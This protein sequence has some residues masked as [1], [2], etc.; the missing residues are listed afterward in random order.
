MQGDE[1]RGL[2]GL[3]SPVV[4]RYY[5]YPRKNYIVMGNV[6]CMGYE[7]ITWLIGRGATG[8]TIA[9]TNESCSHLY[10]YYMELWKKKGA[11]ASLYPQ[12]ELTGEKIRNIFTLTCSSGQ[13]GGIAYIADSTQRLKVPTEADEDLEEMVDVVAVKAID[14]FTRDRQLE[15][16]DFFLAFAAATLA[17]IPG[18]AKQGFSNF[19]IQGIMEGRHDSGLPGKLQPCYI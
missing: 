3:D 17:G 14:T 11:S 13:L 4:P 19:S 10:N 16:L 12:T 6:D 8:V 1:E 18:L 9:S 7:L 5:C 15:D 2:S